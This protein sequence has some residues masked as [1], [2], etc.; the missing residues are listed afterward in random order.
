MSESAGAFGGRGEGSAPGRAG[1][2]LIELA[3]ALAIFGLLATTLYLALGGAIDAS[4]RLRK[5]QE[6]WQ[7][8]RVARSFVAGALRSATPFS[9]LPGDGFVAVDTTRGGIPRDELT[10]T[11]L[12]PGGAGGARMQ[13]HLFV[14]D[15]AGVPELRLEVRE[16]SPVADSLTAADS[17]VLSRGVAGLDVRYL[18]A[19]A[20]AETTWLTRWQTA[21][22][23]PY[24]VRIDFLPGDTP[25]PLY[26]TPLVVQI[27]AGR[28]L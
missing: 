8:G 10:F 7:R 6:P 2:T 14:A 9:G 19:P 28:M 4:D 25:D 21:I 17:H 5:N 1:F 24:A 12:A 18:A 23:L 16:L 26:R 22:R 20:T 27:P 3:V 13:V 11:A 15:S